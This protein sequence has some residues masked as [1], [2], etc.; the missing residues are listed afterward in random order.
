MRSDKVRLNITLP[1][2]VAR[3][4]DELAGQRNKSEFIAEALQAKIQEIRKR[5]LKRLLEEGYQAT[6]REAVAISEEFEAADLEG[7]DEE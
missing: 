6:S 1:K 5:D 4:L 7:L 2:S 3:E